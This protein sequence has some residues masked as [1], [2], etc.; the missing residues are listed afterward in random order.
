MYDSNYEERVSWYPFLSLA[1][2]SKGR[3]DTNVSRENSHL[4]NDNGNLIGLIKNFSDQLTSA[5]ISTSLLAEPRWS[6]LSGPLTSHTEELWTATTST[7]SASPCSK[8][9]EARTSWLPGTGSNPGLASTSRVI[10]SS[11]LATMS[12]A[13]RVHVPTLV[14]WSW[15]FP[16]LLTKIPLTPRS[17]TILLPVKVISRLPVKGLSSEPASNSPW[18]LQ[19]GWHLSW[20]SMIEICHR[21]SM[22]EYIWG[23]FF[24]NSL[25]DNVVGSEVDR[26]GCIGMDGHL[27]KK[28][29]A[30]LDF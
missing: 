12:L 17:S 28:H 23:I 30:P 6:N 5:F 29:Q 19:W 27:C 15:R 22:I 26:D 8:L 1:S 7:T 13:S 20:N 3:L 24:W 25:Y 4:R 11:W 21:N 16:P 9:E 10:T 2:W 14:P 18:L